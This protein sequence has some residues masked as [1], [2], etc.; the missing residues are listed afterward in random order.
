[1]TKPDF[2]AADL[3]LIARCHKAKEAIP[4]LALGARVMF[5]M[6]FVGVALFTG[7]VIWM[8]VAKG[9][10][11]VP[12]GAQAYLVMGWLSTFGVFLASRSLQFENQAV[13]LICKMTEE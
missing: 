9:R 2:D 6:M 12:P 8:Y 5:W 10:G 4:Q 13:R 1:M 3:N 7:V 11:G